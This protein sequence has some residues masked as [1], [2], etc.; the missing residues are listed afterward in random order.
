MP[1]ITLPC[2]LTFAG[3][4]ASATGARTA[5]ATADCTIEAANQVIQPYLPGP[6][7]AAV[8]E[9]HCG[10]LLGAGSRAMVASVRGDCFNYSGWAVFNLVADAWQLIDGGYHAACTR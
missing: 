7:P 4:L 6:D 3:Q 8:K 2:A 5:A 9:V 10:E 1:A